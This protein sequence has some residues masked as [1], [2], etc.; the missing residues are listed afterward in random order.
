MLYHGRTLQLFPGVDRPSYAG[1]RV[2]V[3]ERGDGSLLVSYRGMV[4]TPSEAPALAASLKDQASAILKEIPPAPEQ[5]PG[6][7]R[8]PST[9]NPGKQSS[10][11]IWYEDS[12]LKRRHR[13]LVKA[14]MER[15]RKLGKRIG[16][17]R[18]TERDGFAERFREVVERIGPGGLSHRQAA[19]EL[20]IGFATLRRLLE[21]GRAPSVATSSP[22]PTLIPSV[23]GWYMPET[24]VTDIIAQR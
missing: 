10:P 16:R 13:E 11:T 20:D 8:Q 12:K 17:P 15:A 21:A 22:R 7:E 18:V 9:S 6:W 4:L 1:A 3:Q 14:G 2:E 23:N 5:M 24:E 19:R